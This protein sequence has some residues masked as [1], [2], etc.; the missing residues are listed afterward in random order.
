[1]AA[2]RGPLWGG[3]RLRT[4]CNRQADSLG[5]RRILPLA[6]RQRKVKD[7]DGPFKG[8]VTIQSLAEDAGQPLDRVLHQAGGD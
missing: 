1:M 4:C 3:L 6:R 2:S 8:M 5:G 7:D